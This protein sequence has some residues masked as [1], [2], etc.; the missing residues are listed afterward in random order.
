MLSRGGFDF[1]EQKLME[2]KQKKQ[3]E[4][5]AQ[6]RSIETIVDPLSPNVNW[7]MTRKKKSS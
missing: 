6:S 7:K 5:A 3:S 2:K 4:E 1:L